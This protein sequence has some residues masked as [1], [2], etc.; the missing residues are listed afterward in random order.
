[1]EKIKKLIMCLALMLCMVTICPGVLHAAGNE[2]RFSDP[3]TEKGKDVDILV[4]VFTPNESLTG[5][6]IEVAYDTSML[7][8]QKGDAENVGNGILKIR[9]TPGTVNQEDFHLTFKALETGESDILVN[10]YYISTQN[11]GVLTMACGSSHVIT[12]EAT[13][14]EDRKSVV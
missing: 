7:E 8:F 3:T 6:E 14:E 4:N 12:Q 9:M 10:S 11:G 5:G 2:I 13:Q 1:M